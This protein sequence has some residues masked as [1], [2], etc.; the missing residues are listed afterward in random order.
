MATIYESDGSKFNTNDTLE[1]LQE[2][3]NIVCMLIHTKWKTATEEIEA[4]KKLIE[5]VNKFE[6]VDSALRTMNEINKIKDEIQLLNFSSALVSIANEIVETES[7]E[8]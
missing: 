5:V 2:R 6:V 1:I 8:L 3:S 4:V 7:N